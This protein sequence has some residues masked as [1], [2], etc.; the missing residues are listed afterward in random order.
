MSIKV[1][2]NNTGV[3]SS[4]HDYRA[5]TR[6]VATEENQAPE[7]RRLSSLLE[8]SQALSSTLN[9][10]SAL[11]RMLEILARHHGVVRG[12]ITLLQDTGEL[13]VEAS[14][15]SR[16]PGVGAVPGVGEGITGRV[17]E[18][19]RPRRAARQQRADAAASRLE[20]P[21]LPEQELSFICVPIIMNRKA[22]GPVG[23]SQVQGPTATTTGP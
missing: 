23:R 17:V 6:K 1:S 10:K 4:R 13:R 2:I 22:V 8:V 19:G 15:A 12:I 7:I 21:E 14:E 5:Q 16:S 20:R 3:G 18:T 9:F 11:H